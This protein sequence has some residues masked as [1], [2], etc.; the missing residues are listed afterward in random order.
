MSM[1][2]KPDE[3]VCNQNKAHFSINRHSYYVVSNSNA[4]PS[5]VTVTRAANSSTETY[6]ILLAGSGNTLSNASYYGVFELTLKQNPNGGGSTLYST[7]AQMTVETQTGWHGSG[8][9]PTIARANVDWQTYSGTMSAMIYNDGTTGVAGEY[10]T[11][12]NTTQA[13]GGSMFWSSA[14]IFLRIKL[15]GGFNTTYRGHQQL[16]IIA[17]CCG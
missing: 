15:V 8:Y 9:T 3:I 5:P 1:Q 12:L 11:S 7:A 13:G 10:A 17:K 14:G 4:T 16:Q 2:L 6:D